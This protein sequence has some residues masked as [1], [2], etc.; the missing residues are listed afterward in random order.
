MGITIKD[1][2]RQANVSTTTVSRVINNKPDVSDSTKEKIQK[3][4]NKN[5]YQPNNIARGL[6]LKKTKTIGLIIPDISNP[7]FP[8]IIKGVEHKT[9]DYGYS[10][11]ICDTENQ[12]KQEKS[13]IDLLINN[14]VDG[15]IMS[16]SS[17]SVM[18]LNTIKKSNLSIVQLDRNIPELKYPMVSVDN[19][20]SAYKATEYLINLGH[21][22]V[23]HVTG[24]LNTKPAIDRLKGYKEALKDN[25]IN[26]ID[27]LVI[28]GN[29]SKKS[30]Y[31]A[32]KKMLKNENPT[33]VFFANDLMALGA[34]EVLD[35]NELKIPDDISII[36]HDDI[37]VSS[38]VQPKLTTMR[39]PKNKLGKIAA[40]ILL[41]LI[42]NNKE[43]H[44]DVVLNTELVERQ[45]V[46]KLE[47]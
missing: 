3:I 44:E 21:K 22:K 1:I 2:A 29:Y 31:T 46:K 8:E 43:F 5:N 23:G 26:F 10:V 7:F 11:I 16:L 25:N 28:N 18:D 38:L 36:G 27:K 24:D 35:E 37:D 4:I 17:E 40:K 47:S 13:S 45:S 20:L 19:K 6:V 39:Q 42:E 9:K 32:M 12:I 15:I 34:Y 14:R 33:A 30:G 41:D